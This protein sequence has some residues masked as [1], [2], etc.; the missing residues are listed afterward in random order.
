MCMMNRNDSALGIYENNI[1]GEA[2]IAHYINVVCFRRMDEKHSLVFTERCGLT[3]A[4]I[5]GDRSV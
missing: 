4:Y 1:D 2:H 3:Q 5:T